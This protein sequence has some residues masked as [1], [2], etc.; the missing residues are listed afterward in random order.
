MDRGVKMTT[1]NIFL[2][3]QG[4]TLG[5]AYSIWPFIIMLIAGV[6]IMFLIIN[7]RRKAK[8]IGIEEGDDRKIRQS[9]LKRIL[10]KIDAN[11]KQKPQ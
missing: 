1:F 10:G 4:C 11:Q 3:F 8:K 5:A 6:G 9:I 2:F 7:I